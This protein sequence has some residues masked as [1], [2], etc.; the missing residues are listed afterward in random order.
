MIKFFKKIIFISVISLT[1]TLVGLVVF[2]N[3]NHYLKT[4]FLKYPI[5]GTGNTYTR[6]SEVEDIKN[7]DILFLGSSH[8]YR[9]FDTR[10]FSK[11][12]YST[13]NLGTTSQTPIQSKFLLKKHIK[14]LNPKIIIF[15]VYHITSSINGVEPAID[16]ISNTKNLSCFEFKMCLEIRD[17]EVLKTFIYSFIKKSLLKEKFLEETLKKNDK[18]LKGGFVEKSS[19]YSKYESDFPKISENELSKKQL[20]AIDDIVNISKS[21]NA[22]ILL[23]NTPLNKQYNLSY[24]HN[25]YFDSLMS[26]KAEYINFN[27]LNLYLNDTI[28]FYDKDH[29]SQRGVKLF[30]K[31]LIEKKLDSI[32]P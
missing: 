26:S 10:I 14:Q 18:Y 28:H 19:I 8:T 24:D 6:L 22:K 29:L 3:I 23:V 16:I 31:F 30:N 32:K 27:R 21:N 13:F 25:I 5:G 15:D 11:Y 17:I 7:I 1:T 2:G 12:G 9:G 4:S 20:S